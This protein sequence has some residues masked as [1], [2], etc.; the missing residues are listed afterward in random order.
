MVGAHVLLTASCHFVREHQLSTMCMADQ[1]RYRSAWHMW[2][3]LYWLNLLWN[4]VLTLPIKHH[5]G[6]CWLSSQHTTLKNNSR[7]LSLAKLLI[8]KETI[9]INFE[10][11]QPSCK[12]SFQQINEN[13]QDRFLKISSTQSHDCNRDYKPFVWPQQANRW[14]KEILWKIIRRSWAWRIDGTIC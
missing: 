1:L 6:G 11:L 4:G 10:Q 5:I 13:K 12:L 2:M 9:R 7:H 8:R 3:R 14:D